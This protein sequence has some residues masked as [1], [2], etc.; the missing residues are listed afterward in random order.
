[1]IKFFRKIR[2][3]LLMDNKIR[4]Y[5]KYAIGEIVLV[6]I[7]ILIALWINNKNEANKERAIVR[8]MLIEYKMEL[9]YNLEALDRRKKEVDSRAS[10]CTTLLDQIENEL[11]YADTLSTYFNVL[12]LGLLDNGLSMTAFSAIEQRGLNKISDDILKNK[13]IDL[14]SEKYKILDLRT[15]NAMLNVSEYARPIARHKLKYTENMKLVPLDYDALMGDVSTWN[16]LKI[17]HQNYS[18]IS[19]KIVNTQN[20][21][22]EVDDLINR[23]LKLK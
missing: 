15:K 5:F 10:K 9:A 17:L 21:I 6:V 18:E 13:I 7:G 22:Q 20:E 16:I 12:T 19:Y 11:P 8:K 1:M 4:K 23:Y 3:N 2:Q 14:H